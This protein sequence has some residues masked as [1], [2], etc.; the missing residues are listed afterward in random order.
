MT[1]PEEMQAYAAAGVNID[2]ANIAKKLIARY[3]RATHGPQ[4]LSDIGFFGGLFELSGY[5]NPVLVSSADGVGTKIK[6]ASSLGVYDT[7][8][9]DLVNHCINKKTS[10]IEIE[11]V[12]KTSLVFHKTNMV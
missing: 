6:I 5:R 10:A 3:A 7:V 12:D 11:D 1:N 4:V 8:G 9:I 2:A